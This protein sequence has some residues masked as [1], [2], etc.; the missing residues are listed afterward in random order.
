MDLVHRDAFEQDEMVRDQARAFWPAWFGSFPEMDYHVTRTIAAESVVITE[1]VFLGTNSGPLT[2]PVF[3]R[4]IE[5]T[6]R[7]VRFRGVSIYDV[8]GGL[9]QKESVYLDLATLFVELGV[10]V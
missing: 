9:I 2:E 1:W 3:G 7:T 8:T 5:A 10:N 6:G 4:D